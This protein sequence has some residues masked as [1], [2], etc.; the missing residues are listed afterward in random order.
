ML[1]NRMQYGWDTQ[2]ETQ[3]RKKKSKARKNDLKTKQKWSQITESHWGSKC[4]KDFWELLQ[5]M[6]FFSTF[7]I[8]SIL[9]EVLICSSTKTFPT[10]FSLEHILMA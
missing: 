6:I 7:L 3:P 2:N 8:A 4:L 1:V 9:K 5:I 10:C